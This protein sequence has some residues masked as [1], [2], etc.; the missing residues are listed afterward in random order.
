MK[1]WSIYHSLLFIIR[2][3]LQR[4]FF[5]YFKLWTHAKLIILF[6]FDVKIDFDMDLAE[7]WNVL[8]IG[9]SAFWDRKCSHPLIRF[10]SF[11]NRIHFLG[12]AFWDRL[13]TTTFFF[14]QFWLAKNQIHNFFYFLSCKKLLCSVFFLS[15]QQTRTPLFWVF[16]MLGKL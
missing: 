7:S 2:L 13:W 12:G 8:K 14:F 11:Q 9:T 1:S 10:L 16:F 4:F 6:D 5:I 15:S 3:I